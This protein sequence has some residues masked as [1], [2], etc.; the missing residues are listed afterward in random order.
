MGPRASLW[1]ML[2]RD[3]SQYLSK[4]FEF[5][6]NIFVPLFCTFQNICTV[7]INWWLCIIYSG[8]KIES[9]PAE[10]SRRYCHGLTNFWTWSH[11]SITVLFKI[12][13][14]LLLNTCNFHHKQRFIFLNSFWEIV[15]FREAKFQFISG[16]SPTV[17]A[18]VTLGFILAGPTLNLQAPATLDILF[19]LDQLWTPACYARS[20]FSLPNCDSRH[21][22]L[23]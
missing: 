14:N 12:S 4:S 11:F 20:Y 1:T 9:G 8:N 2:S 5:H 15:L 22:I 18:P 17:L 21:S 10:R 3:S 6:E 16:Y 23:F 13:V 19:K 7:Y